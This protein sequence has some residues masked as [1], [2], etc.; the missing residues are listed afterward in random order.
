MRSN[1]STTAVSVAVVMTGLPPTASRDDLH[2]APMG[3][4]FASAAGWDTAYWT[5]QDLRFG[6]SDMFARDFNA[7]LRVAG[8][9]LDDRADLDMGGDDERLTDH[10]AKNIGALREPYFAVVHL[11]NTHSPYFVDEA[12]APFQ[13]SEFTKD[14]DKSTDFFNYYRN[15]V[16]RQDAAVARLV[17]AV[18][19]APGGERTVIVFTSD[20]GEAFRE[21]YQLGHTL[22]VYDEELH[23]PAWVD[24]P[25]GTLDEAEARSLAALR[26]TPVFH[27]D[28][29]PTFLDL[30]GLGD[31][32]E[33]ARY[34]ARFEGVSLLRGAAGRDRVVPLTNCAAV[35]TCPFRNWGTMQGSRKLEARQWDPVWHCWDLAADP[36]ERRDLGAAAC[37]QQATRALE[38]FGALPSA[39]LR[40]P[41][42]EG[43]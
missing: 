23:V 32:P 26:T 33:L 19:R 40:A 37:G 11:A 3:W 25:P 9:D 22:S 13:P 42:R 2:R 18:R 15:A 30:M 20:H 8:A 6:N 29:L 38:L 5:S 12:R 1:D 43:R 34:R 31:A 39:D 7:R 17:E 36:G 24:A 14:P 21:H 35:W 28:L 41:L 16:Y 27:T 10:V 4:E